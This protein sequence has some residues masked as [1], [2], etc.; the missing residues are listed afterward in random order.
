MTR[1]QLTAVTAAVALF[2]AHQLHAMPFLE[3]RQS[4]IQ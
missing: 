1:F 4:S 3:A 2:S